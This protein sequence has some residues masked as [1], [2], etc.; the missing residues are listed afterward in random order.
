M[1]CADCL[2]QKK[3][4][5]RLTN[6]LSDQE[7]K[8]Q[9]LERKLQKAN[10]KNKARL[11]HYKDQFLEKS[12]SEEILQ[13]QLQKFTNRK[14]CDKAT[15]CDSDIS[16]NNTASGQEDK[17]SPGGAVAFY[18]ENIQKDDECSSFTTEL[19]FN[20]S[21][22]EPVK[23]IEKLN[24]RLSGLLEQVET[25][26]KKVVNKEQPENSSSLS[27]L[28]DDL[29]IAAVKKKREKKVKFDLSDKEKDGRIQDLEEKLQRSELFCD[30]LREENEDLRF[31]IADLER[32]LGENDVNINAREKEV[33]DLKQKINKIGSELSESKNQ[34]NDSKIN[35]L[36]IKAQNAS[37]LKELESE[38]ENLKISNSDLLEKME[39]LQER[40]SRL[41]FS[42]SDLEESLKS[43]D[44]KLRSKNEQYENLMENLLS[45]KLGFDEFKSQS[46]NIVLEF[47]SDLEKL[48]VENGN[49]NMQILNLRTEN[50]NFLI[51]NSRLLNDKE[52]LINDLNQ[53]KEAIEISNE[54]INFLE[55][56]QGAAKLKID[57][58]DPVFSRQNSEY[59]LKFKAYLTKMNVLQRENEKLEDE[60]QKLSILLE[61]C[62]V[63]CRNSSNDLSSLK[64]ELDSEKAQRSALEKSLKDIK[65][66]CDRTTTDSK[67]YISKIEELQNLL[68]EKENEFQSILI[69]RRS[70]DCQLRRDFEKQNE[71]FQILKQQFQQSLDEKCEIESE[72][73]KLWNQDAAS[74]KAL[75]DMEREYCKI[76]QEKSTLEKM[77]EEQCKILQDLKTKLIDQ[78]NSVVEKSQFDNFTAPEI[79][80]HHI[81]GLENENAKLKNRVENLENR[82]RTLLNVDLQNLKSDFCKVNKSLIEERERNVDLHDQLQQKNARFL[83]M[84]NSTETLLGVISD[85][86]ADLNRLHSKLE[87]LEFQLE[88]LRN[89]NSNLTSQIDGKNQL[90]FDLLDNLKNLQSKIEYLARRNLNLNSKNQEQFL[91]LKNWIKNLR[92]EFQ[93]DI[94]SFNRF[95]TDNLEKFGNIAISINREEN[96][97]DQQHSYEELH[98]YYVQLQ[99][100]YASLYEQYE[101][102]TSS[103]SSTNVQDQC[104]S[105]VTVDL[106]AE[107]N[108]MLQNEQVSIN[109]ESPKNYY[110]EAVTTNYINGAAPSI[111]Q[112]SSIVEN[113]VQIVQYKEIEHLNNVTLA[114]KL[115]FVQNHINKL[116]SENAALQKLQKSSNNEIYGLSQHVEILSKELDSLKEICANEK[117]VKQSL[118]RNCEQLYDT[119]KLLNEEIC[120]LK[121]LCKRLDEQKL[122]LECK[123]GEQNGTLHLGEKFKLE[124]KIRQSL[125]EICESKSLDLLEHCKLVGQ[126]F[127]ENTAEISTLKSACKRLDE[128]KCALEYEGKSA[129]ECKL[130]EKDSTLHHEEKNEIRQ[131]LNEIC[132]SNCQN[133][134]EHCKIVGQIFN[135]N[136]E[137]ISTLKSAY[138]AEE[139]STLKSRCKQLGEEKNQLEC[140]LLGKDSILHHDKKL[141]IETKNSEILEYRRNLIL[142]KNQ[143]NLHEKDL[144]IFDTQIIQ[145]LNEK[146]WK[147]DEIIANCQDL[148]EKSRKINLNNLKLKS[149]VQILEDQNRSLILELDQLKEKFNSTQFDLNL[150]SQQ[151]ENQ[152][153]KIVDLNREFSAKIQI[154]NEQIKM[155]ESV[156]LMSKNEDDAVKLLL[157]S[158]EKSLHDWKTRYFDLEIKFDDQ[159]SQLSIFKTR[160]EELECS[161]YEKK[162]KIQN[163]LVQCSLNQDLEK[164]N[165]NLMTQIENL[166][167][168]FAEN[169][170]KFREMT[171]FIDENEIL[172]EFKFENERLISEIDRLKSENQILMDGTTKIE[173]EFKLVKFEYQQRLEQVAEDAKSMQ[174]ENQRLMNLNQISNENTNKYVQEIHDLKT[175]LIDLR[176]ICDNLQTAAQNLQLL[177]EKVEKLEKEKLISIDQCRQLSDKLKIFE[178]D[179]KSE[180]GTSKQLKTAT[181]EA[182]AL[183]ESLEKERST[184]NVRSKE[185]L[186][187][188]TQLAFSERQL[189]DFRIKLIDSESSHRTIKILKSKLKE[190]SGEKE[191]LLED[192]CKLKA[193]LQQQK[194]EN[195]VKQVEI[196]ENVGN[197]PTSSNDFQEA[198]IKS[199]SD[200][201][202]L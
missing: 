104:T 62:Q 43:A 21:I 16:N 15:D 39:K 18:K 143:L 83:E 183:I 189:E 78:E 52:I 152:E 20:D 57:E 192:N 134:L 127:N 28:V 110:S 95:L 74:K 155:L 36:K 166:E 168:K 149:D 82:C 148:M 86:E 71:E 91:I 169:S 156:N 72:L 34:F 136:V 187:L 173:S 123:L 185:L 53:L 182:K 31:T 44:Q 50:E 13:Q 118:Q 137:E 129:L 126:Y 190:V 161:I 7:L 77:Y 157:E 141:E 64:K 140:K 191:R 10:L 2:E 59:R 106:N 160:I 6:A 124:K 144:Q 48:H 47:E 49:L 193:S 158:K 93:D 171:S 150:K 68:D 73:S 37:R 94:R 45:A 89:E 19:T 88:N 101:K 131:I 159:K 102:M 113:L 1:P 70:S 100:A 46:E 75:S 29:P 58:R 107:F 80:K 42:V 98:A 145:F 180:I 3:I 69:D 111:D 85:K 128:E 79:S 40:N 99:N 96:S 103:S 26:Q 63:F 4:L 198:E 11:V 162:T 23:N 27:L 135:D 139:I 197:F 114:E 17:Y 92:L 22:T 51:E 122:E 138:S 146:L 121:I 41:E 32:R 175:Q 195:E 76:L 151:L 115:I 35:V 66:T 87:N 194:N 200:E 142:F 61:N 60:I 130:L 5:V 54:F 38:V 201:T 81:D 188:K 202:A 119:E 33:C 14:F 55:E 97:K 153:C 170:A 132:P 12:N 9:D 109:S 172:S 24:T 184:N 65:T 176:K 179:R 163:A 125:N 178:K 108:P 8:C 112:C 181:K 133:L 90:F 67:S 30:D 167:A 164:K 196:L 154:L 165:Q 105:L 147:I 25:M 56:N 199:S 177:E 117:H 174:E 116:L 120:G 186:D 84:E